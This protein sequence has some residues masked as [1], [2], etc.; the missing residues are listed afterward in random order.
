MEGARCKVQR[1]TCIGGG[2]GRYGE[3]PSWPVID[4]DLNNKN[5]YWGKG[6]GI[7]KVPRDAGGATTTI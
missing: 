1:E 6:G 4:Y 7:G 3:R 5:K 2:K